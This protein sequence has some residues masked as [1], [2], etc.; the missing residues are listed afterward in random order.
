[1]KVFGM[2]LGAA[3]AAVAGLL[4]AGAGQAAEPVKIGYAI[5]KSGMFAPIGESQI[6]AYDLWAEQ[7]NAKGGLD[8]AGEKRPIE[9][10]VYD[11]QSDF[12]KAPA[13]Y[14]KLI[15]DDKVDLLLAP[16]GTPFHFAIAGVLEKHKFPMVGNTAASVQLRD[17][18]PGNIWFP[19]SAIPD[20]MAAELVK[21]LQ[22]Q[23]VK[24]VTV[25]TLQLPFSQE[26]KKYLM[27]ELQKA[28]IEVAVDEEYAP[29][30]KDLTA[31]LT[32]VRDAK[33][34]AVLSLSYPPDSVLYMN[35]ARELGI[36]APLQFLLVGPTADFFGKMFGAGLDGIITMGH[37]SPAQA[38]WAKAKPFFDAF[39]QKYSAKP[40]YLDT[41]LAWMS[42]E[43][44]E[45]A[46]AKA[47]LDKD[48]LRQVISTDTFDTINGPVKFNGVENATTPTMFLQFQG[49]E[50]QIV[51]PESEATA[52]IIKKPAWTK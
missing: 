27:P 23:G 26:V 33:P 42:C 29:G 11:D 15:T 5:S 24:K 45:Q 47:G 32:K 3:L 48:K 31:T 51:W 21:M 43:I 25:T 41:A 30:V 1:M 2:R 34:D 12:G 20:R 14:E 17:L 49:D 18:A 9:F 44:L 50:A 7:V 40:D 10:V 16:W 38:K 35:Q 6:Q 52:K 46:V 8:V 39:V 19:T 13:I 22:S 28:G 36:D 37:W 4:L